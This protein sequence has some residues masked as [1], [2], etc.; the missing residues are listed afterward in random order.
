MRMKIN[1]AEACLVSLG[2]VG[3]RPDKFSGIIVRSLAV[4]ANVDPDGRIRLEVDLSKE[5][6]TLRALVGLSKM[7]DVV[8]HVRNRL[9]LG[10][11]YLP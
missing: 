4:L 3:Q 11:R 7:E 2:K 1:W 8:F 5:E 6:L 10:C 9:L